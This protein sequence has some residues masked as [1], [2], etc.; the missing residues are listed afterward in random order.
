VQPGLHGADAQA[1]EF[2]GGLLVEA[3]DVAEYEY[4]PVLRGQPSEYVAD[5]RRELRIAPGGQGRE[6]G[7]DGAGGLAGNP[8]RLPAGDGP[9]PSVECGRL[10][11]GTQAAEDGD[12]RLLYGVGPVGQG[13]R[14][15]DATDVRGEGVQEV[16]HREG[17]TAL[18]KAHQLLY[19]VIPYVFA[20]SGVTQ[21]RSLVGVGVG[22]GD[23]VGDGDGAEISARRAVVAAIASVRGV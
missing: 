2:G 11:Q 6:V 14:R 10:L 22:V 21:L 12:E 13:D 3:L 9:Y 18:G 8:D 4:G 16:V 23:G 1:E 7:G 5:V 20:L 17:V 15:T 19:V